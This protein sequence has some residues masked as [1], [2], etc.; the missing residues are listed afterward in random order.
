[1]AARA[2][3]ARH[4]AQ[5]P[6]RSTY[7]LVSSDALLLSDAIAELRRRA[8]TV[9]PDF[10]VDELEANAGM[11]RILAAARTLPMMAPTRWVH[12]RDI[13]RLPAKEHPA[14]TAY[15]AAPASST[16]LVLSAPKLDGRTKLAQALNKSGALFNLEPPRPAELP[17]WIIERAKRAGYGI[18]GDAAALLA[19]L[20]GGELG[21]LAA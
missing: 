21:I 17:G 5:E 13:S 12:V 19:D 4:L 16:V 3:L 15:L 20:I 9:A 10:N 7:A 1:M 14:L 8:V 2:D 18:Q 6:L 11:D